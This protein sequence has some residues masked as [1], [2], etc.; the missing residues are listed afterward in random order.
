MFGACGK[1]TAQPKVNLSQLVVPGVV[2]PHG[3]E[4]LPDGTKV[5]FHG[6]LLDG[7]SN[8]CYKAG[9]HA[10]GENLDKRGGI[11]NALEVG[12]GIQPLVELAPLAP[13]GRLFLEKCGVEAM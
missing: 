4:Y 3:Y 5:L 8:G 10:L 7:D 11:P 12:W 9:A 13:G 2:V 6:P 1:L